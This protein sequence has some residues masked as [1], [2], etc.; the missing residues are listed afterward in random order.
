MGHAFRLL[1]EDQVREL[2]DPTAGWESVVTAYRD[3]GR[4]PEVLSK[5]PVMTIGPPIS[6]DVQDVV[7]KFRVKGGSVPSYGAAGAF[8]WTSGQ[9]FIY[10]WSIEQGVPTGLVACNWLSKRRVALTAAVGIETLGRSQIG[11]IVLFGAGPW[12][13]QTCDVIAE[14]WPD[15]EIVVVTRHPERGAAFAAT[16]PDNVVPGTD[17]RSAMRGADVAVTMTNTVDPII[18]AG[19]LEPGGLVLAMGYPHEVEI[20]ALRQ[21]DAMLVDDLEYARFQGSIAA[22]LKRGDI[23]EA[24]IEQRLRANIG[25]VLIGSKP[26]RLNDGE[27][28]V[29]MVQGLAVCDIAIA[30][31]MLTR[32]EAS[33]TGQV[34]EL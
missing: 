30:Q 22:W 12:N 6:P 13:D 29:A 10:L 20:E 25:E 24:E 1:S 7:V 19:D 14:R 9:S 21:A 34:V 32:A 31:A 15:A 2:Y 33:S 16:K 18:R 3:F 5:P 23:D 8:L 4:S 17:A 28:L 27:R 11:K 26:G